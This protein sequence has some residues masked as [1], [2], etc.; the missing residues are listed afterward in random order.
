ML[1]T[2][3][4]IVLALWLL[5]MVTAHSMGGLLHL[6]LGVALIIILVRVLSGRRLV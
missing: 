3:L 1:N 5:G 6:L 2:I 4:I